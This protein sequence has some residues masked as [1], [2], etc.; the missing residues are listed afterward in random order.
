MDKETVNKYL[1]EQM[2][3]CW[4][5]WFVVRDEPPFRVYE[6]K[7][8]KDGPI[9]NPGD[10]LDLFSPEGFVKL[11]DWVIKEGMGDDFIEHTWQSLVQD[12]FKPDWI[13]FQLGIRPDLV[14]PSK[15]A[16]EIY[17]YLKQKD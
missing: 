11:W 14:N 15:L 12:H 4:H 13:D 2:G 10:N 8:C 6:C 7:R 9:I 1:A 16:P 5:E 3:L 17:S